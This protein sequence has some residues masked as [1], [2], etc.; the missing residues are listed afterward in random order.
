LVE[1]GAEAWE[2]FAMSIMRTSVAVAVP[3][4]KNPIKRGE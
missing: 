4:L 2:S 1:G 3:A